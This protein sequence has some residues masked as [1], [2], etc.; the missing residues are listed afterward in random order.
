[1]PF[2]TPLALL[3]LLFVPAV[4]AMYL[5]KLR[6]DEAVVPSTLLWT[7]LVADI[8]ANAPWQKLRRSLLLLLQL[9]L[10]IAL[11][12]LAAR[13]FLERPAGL[14]R[15]IVLVMDTSASMGATDVVPDRLTAAKQ[16]AIEALK[17]LPTGGKVSVIAA[18]RS[19]RIVVNESRDLSRVRQAIEGI[20]V[21]QS[22]GDLGDALELASKLAAR[23]GEAQ[24]LVATDA[25][26]ARTPV[27]RVAA[28]IK[29]L[30]VGRERKNQA[31]VALAIRTSPSAVTRSV[32]VSVANLDLVEAAR[33]LEV[34][35][36]DRLLEVRDV[37]LDAQRRSDV[38]IDD[39]PREVRTVEVRL[40]G[41]DPSVTVAPDQLAVDDR[42]WAVVPPD[43]KR[44]ILIVGEGDAYLETAL[45]F[46]PDV[47][48]FGVTPSEYG[49]KTDRTDGRQWDLVIF[50]GFLPATLP[51]TPIL[52]IAPPRSS[53]L[54]DV[55]GTLKDPGIGTLDPDEP[56][57]R[58]VDLSTTHI[59]AAAKLTAPTWARTIIPGPRGAPLLYAGIRDGI[60]QAVLAFEPRRS[61]LPLQVAFPILLAN[62]T[63]E[64]FGSTAA[65]TE[66]VE[67][68]AP[69]QLVIPT[70]A[71]GLSI[72]RPDG[73]VSEL[74]P[75]TTAG[76]SGAAVTFA[77]TDLLGVYTVTPI[78][79]TAASPGPSA[80]GSAA[81]S[82]GPSASAAPS[83]RPIASPGASGQPVVVDPLAPVRF[84]VDLFDVDESTI[85]P[86]NPSTIAALGIGPEASPA[87]GA[88]GQG[89]SGAGNPQER[90]TTRDELWVP[91][92]L[93]IIAFLCVEWALYHR[94]GLIKLRRSL[95]ERL[96]R[97]RAGSVSR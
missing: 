31:I 62:L 13:P 87:P 35:G 93:A 32:F 36:D 38:I 57:L 19:A 20:P 41:A 10:V 58:Y 4:I 89:G 45:S 6:R 70:G 53:A 76:A 8:E 52:A 81:P 64:L 63:G 56:V 15:D 3:G 88:S 67:P 59:S 12:L 79:D 55:S 61:D 44:L 80:G 17:G 90:P 75:S 40:V 94:D 91:I 97:A 5:L 69:V 33:R 74:V 22:R 68:G 54:G 25:A 9:L 11:A 46:L 18:D 60:N 65:P 39:L 50:E 43:R 95:G 42:A 66:A 29:V 1:V 16:V 84:A 83:A 49:P 21:T 28:P 51:K 24:F 86:G 26:L 78:P 71:R 48:L 30:T 77:A 47:E 37:R 85:A 96:G 14:A 73:I 34:W 82:G 72:S 27:G 2:T 92:V 23:S 7:R